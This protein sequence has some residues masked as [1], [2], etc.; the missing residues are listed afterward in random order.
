[1]VLLDFRV[2]GGEV[3]AGGSCFGLDGDRLRQLAGQGDQ[4]AAGTRLPSRDEPAGL[5]VVE[6]VVA[7]GRQRLGRAD[8][9]N[10]S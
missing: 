7:R 3:F 9:V 10:V 6:R 5:N 4:S 1:V 8:D 2:V